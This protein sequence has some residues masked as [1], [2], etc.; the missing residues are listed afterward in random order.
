[1]RRNCLLKHVTDEKIEG[2]IEGKR[3]ERRRRKQLLGD[4]EKRRY[5]TLKEK[6]LN[7]DLWR[8]CFG[9]GHEPVVAQS[10]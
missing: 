5:L 8:T 4:K 7:R 3:R 10:A 6:A 2:N 9:R 1:L